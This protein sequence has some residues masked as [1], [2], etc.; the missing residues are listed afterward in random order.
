MCAI[1]DVTSAIPT[2]NNSINS[3]S[4]RD[5]ASCEFQ[6]I[7]KIYLKNAMLLSNE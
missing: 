2:S 3:N 4:V 7:I 6:K 5:N 1:A